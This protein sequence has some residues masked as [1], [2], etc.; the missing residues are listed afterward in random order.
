MLTKM[1]PI[2]PSV[3]NAPSPQI[4]MHVYWSLCVLVPLY[5][6]PSP[7]ARHSHCKVSLLVPSMGGRKSRRM[8]I[9]QLSYFGTSHLPIHNPYLS[10]LLYL[11]VPNLCPNQPSKLLT[12]PH[13]L[14]PPTPNNT[15]Y[16]W[17]P[18]LPFLIGKPN[19]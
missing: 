18:A 9:Q 14:L 13:I 12:P 6:S 5:S 17:N 11:I 8:E 3:A 19:L 10:I 7:L 2:D 1:V 4:S 15:T 16:T